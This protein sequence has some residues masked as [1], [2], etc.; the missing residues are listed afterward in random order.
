MFL[1]P[2]FVI[3]CEI[4]KQ[5][6]S[7]NIFFFFFTLSPF[8]CLYCNNDR[9]AECFLLHNIKCEFLL[10]YISQIVSHVALHSS[11]WNQYIDLQSLESVCGASEVLHPERGSVI[12]AVSLSFSIM[13][14]CDS[15]SQ[16]P[17][18]SPLSLPLLHSRHTN[19][20]LALKIKD[21]SRKIIHLT[22]ERE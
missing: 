8:Q 3:C 9:L 14:H 6:I 13:V 4:Y 16:L 5:F 11:Y 20:K 21:Q 19:E 18:C 15:S 2:F 1:I 17:H 22:A 12:M 7:E 10:H